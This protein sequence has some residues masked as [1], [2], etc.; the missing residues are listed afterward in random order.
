MGIKNR[1]QKLVIIIGLITILPVLAWFGYWLF[2]NKIN[3]ETPYL[4]CPIRVLDGN[5]G[6]KD[7]KA[8]V[9]LFG[10]S[11]SGSAGYT[12][13]S[14]S[15]GCFIVP[16]ELRNKLKAGD[17]LQAT[18]ADSLPDRGGKDTAYKF[19]NIS[20]LPITKEVLEGA[21]QIIMKPQNNIQG[22]VEAKAATPTT[23]EV[24]TE[25]I[26]E[27]YNAL[28]NI[29]PD[30]GRGASYFG[31]EPVQDAKIVVTSSDTQNLIG[32][33]T[34]DT[35][36]IC[37][38]TYSFLNNKVNELKVTASKEGGSPAF[39]SP[40]TETLFISYGGD[41]Y[42]SVIHA[43]IFMWPKY[44]SAA[45]KTLSGTSSNKY[46]QN[47]TRQF[48]AQY[49]ASSPEEQPKWW[50]ENVLQGTADWLATIICALETDKPG[51]YAP[52]PKLLFFANNLSNTPAAYIVSGQANIAVDNSF[53]QLST[54]ETLRKE[55]LAHEYGHVI[56]E[57]GIGLQ[58]MNNGGRY[59]GTVNWNNLFPLF[60]TK[61]KP[62]TDVIISPDSSKYFLNNTG[63][64]WAEAFERY[65]WDSLNQG[66]NLPTYNSYN[67]TELGDKDITQNVTNFT[68]KYLSTVLSTFCGVQD[69][70]NSIQAPQ[71]ITGM[72]NPNP[73]SG[74]P[75]GRDYTPDEIKTG[76]YKKVNNESHNIPVKISK[77]PAGYA[78]QGAEIIIVPST[79][80]DISIPIGDITSPPELDPLKTKQ[81]CGYGNNYIKFDDKPDS[82]LYANDVTRR[83]LLGEMERFDLKAIVKN[84][85]CGK[86]EV[87]TIAGPFTLDTTKSFSEQVIDFAKLTACDAATPLTVAPTS[88]TLQLGSTGSLI[89]VSGGKAPY[90]IKVQDPSY[91][92]V[93]KNLT[94]TKETKYRVSPLSPGAGKTTK[95][96]VSDSSSPKGGVVVNVTISS[97]GALTFT[98][99]PVT[100]A[101][102]SAVSGKISGGTSP[103]S[104]TRCDKKN[105][106]TE[107]SKNTSNMVYI[108]GKKVGSDSFTVSDSS[109]PKQSISVPVTI[110]DTTGGG[111]GGGEEDTQKP[112]VSI[113]GVSQFQKVSKTVNITVAATDNVKVAKVWLKIGSKQ[114]AISANSTLSYSW[115]TTKY[116]N[117]GIMITG[118]AQDTSGN[119]G[120]MSVSAYVDNSTP[121]SQSKGISGVLTKLTDG[122]RYGQYRYNLLNFY[123][124]LRYPKY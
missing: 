28:S 44:S 15:Q 90:S 80:R 33:C 54:D 49:F 119:M 106:A 52:I 67:I 23:T 98:P 69:D 34:T 41:S 104:A 107:Q 114:V 20:H 111:G 89:S 62:S 96:F 57:G 117:G 83:I 39:N 84:P 18:L 25:L 56:D 72:S 21:K 1:R 73:N 11:E 30:D 13:T 32:S 109:K 86:N 91:L 26:F 85:K 2:Q 63:E 37:N 88:L 65:M 101:K 43:E 35:S 71:L 24:N 123:Y 6:I 64:F 61:E 112:S 7:I 120:G 93:A 4:N 68:Q 100:V 36:G 95:L 14:D 94:S 99:S 81:W 31:R 19:D 40:V 5:V 8:L 124:K 76:A 58:L 115:D 55:M 92:S 29:G 60:G 59:S 74:G 103:F 51:I 3:A 75:L 122:L 10:V 121:R 79:D 118:G 22:K 70:D 46:C 113:L 116:Q 16:R 38:I 53:T 27:V 47:K 48:E 78:S 66:G 97:V 82:Q 42:L 9:P 108:T 110:T 105:C 50:S 45:V 87:K 12:L 17:Y 77:L 102:S